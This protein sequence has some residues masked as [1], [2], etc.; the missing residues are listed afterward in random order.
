LYYSQRWTK[1]RIARELHIGVKTVRRALREEADGTY[2]LKE[3]RAR[4]VTADIEPLIVGLLETEAERQTPRKQ[5]LSAAAI[6]EILRRQHGYTGSD[7]SVRRAV[8]RVRETRGD[9]L[10]GAMVP[11]VYEPG[12]DAQVDFLEGDVD[13]PT[14]RQRRHFVLVRA[15]YSTKPFAYHA[16]AENQEALFDGLILAFEHFGGVFHHLWFDNL[17]LAVA[18]V[19]KSR[20]R[21]VHARFAALAAQYGFV[22]EFCG[23]GKG[24][25]KGGVENGVRY[26]Q[27]RC[28]TPVPEV[29]DDE[30]LTAWVRAWVAEQTD[31]RPTGRDQTIGQL[32]AQEQTVLI[33]LPGR[34]FDACRTTTRGVSSYSLVQDGTNFYSVP[35]NLAKG[36]VTLKRYAWTVELHDSS[37]LVARH[38][39]LYGRGQVSFQLAHYLPLLERKTRA[40]DRAAPVKAVRASWPA[41]YELLLRL[42]RASAGEA[43]GTREFIQVLKLHEHHALGDVHE[44]VRRALTHEAPSLSAVRRELERLTGAS[45][46]PAPLAE[47]ATAHLPV[48]PVATGDVAAYGQLCGGTD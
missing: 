43:D 21:E 2:R 13:Y 34:R 44:A 19:L 23:V 11:L 39:R 42:L 24:N 22:A 45:Q 5:R 7:I 10:A 12:V 32:W 29:A 4:P 41:T 48:V 47:A 36:S 8:A 20:S 15:C 14:G 1:K 18:R 31:R 35:V 38:K 25:E 9:P 27:R 6:E 37:G 16:P 26:F 30:A 28:L 46:L 3:P 33:P 40:F 17:T